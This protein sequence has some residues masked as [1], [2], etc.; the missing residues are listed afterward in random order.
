M[1]E[2]KTLTIGTGDDATKAEGIM[3]PEARAASSCAAT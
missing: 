1:A 3:V 2:F